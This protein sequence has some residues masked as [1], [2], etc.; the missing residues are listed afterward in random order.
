VR[1][2]ADINARSLA[3]LP[4]SAG[5]VTSGGV[6][7]S[8]APDLLDDHGWDDIVHA[9]VTRIV[10]LRNG[11]ERESL[12]SASAIDVVHAPL[13]DPDDPDYMALW[14][15]NWAHPDFYAWGI[16][17]WPHLWRAALGGVADA[18]A[19]VVLVHCAGGRDR[20]GMVSAIL[21]ETAG[22]ERGAIL[23]DYERGI[24][25]TNEMLR[26]RGESDSRHAVPEDRLPDVVSRFR[27][28]LNTLLDTAPRLL[29]EQDLGELARRAAARLVS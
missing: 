28:G 3:G 26:R 10:D 12:R 17:R 6:W 14:E 13:E 23:D 24:L 27:A 16:S 7:R 21:L 4:R 22:V 20:T 15:G 18:P 9:G 19:G 11:S 29:D 5:G 1:F 8:A 25:G 2:D